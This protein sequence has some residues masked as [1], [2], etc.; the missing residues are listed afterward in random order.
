MRPIKL[1]MSAFGPYAE[2]EVLELDKLGETGLYLITG[3]TGAGKTTIFDAIT[4]ALYGEASGDSREASMMRSKYADPQTPTYVELTFLYNG[5][6]YTIHRV[7]EYMRPRV[8]G[9]GETKQKSEAVLTMPDGQVIDKLTDVNAKIIEIV[10]INRNQFVQIAMI[11]Q[12]DFQKLLL[13]KTEDRQKIFREIF[14]TKM[15]QI[16]QN[17]LSED[18]SLLNRQCEDE[19]HAISQYLSDISAD[20]NSPY[21]SKVMEIEDGAYMV[22]EAMGLILKV[23][24]EDNGEIE[25]KRNLVDMLSKEVDEIKDKI[26][27]GS[28]YRKTIENIELAKGAIDK[29][30]IDKEQAD[31]KLKE[32][33]DNEPER[34][35]IIKEIALIKKDMG[36]YSELDDILKQIE[37]YKGE[38]ESGEE[39]LIEKKKSQLEIRDKLDEDKKSLKNL[40]S[41][42]LNHQKKKAKLDVEN[43]KQNTLN[44]LFEAMDECEVIS[45]EYDE[46]VDNYKKS[47]VSSNELHEEYQLKNRLFMD[48]QAGILAQGL[49]EGQPC[50][51]CGSTHHPL[52]AKTDQEAPTQQELKDAEERANAALNRT[53]EL[54]V[55]AGEKKATR[56]IKRDNVADMQEKILGKI[57]DGDISEKLEKYQEELTETIKT[58]NEDIKKLQNDINAKAKLEKGIPDLEIKL[59]D[60]ERSILETE[61]GIIEHKTKLESDEKHRD[62]IKKKLRYADKSEAESAVGVLEDKEKEMK[63]QLKAWDKNANELG[64]RL[65]EIKGNLVELTKRKDALKEYDVDELDR[66]L[67]EKN[68][69]IAEVGD[70][71]NNIF[72][73]VEANKKAYDNVSKA[74][75][76]LLKLEEKWKWQSSIS[77]TANGNVAGKERIMLETYIQSTY[78]DRVLARAAVRL[79]R[80]SGGQYELV[81]KKTAKDLRSQTGL[82][83]DVI[84]HNASDS[85]LRDVSTLSGGEQ[86]MASLSLALGLSDEIRDSAGGIKL[87]AMFVDEGFGSLSENV[88][89]EA[90]KVLTELSTDGNRLIG[91]ISHVAD[92]KNKSVNKIVVEKSRKK[93]S[94][95]RIELE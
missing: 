17:R 28:D 56:D 91:I 60:I 83:I 77:K 30:K 54:S 27:T 73:R 8:K 81:R 90:W 43:E 67:T 52:L 33:R 31:K 3:D 68:E 44:Q 84:D 32:L 63:E 50:R 70:D 61:K 2:K 11:A 71:I 21:H 46:A 6:E 65:A 29:V 95:A 26:K 22:D 62:D 75:E 69:R 38:I 23:I 5:K 80:M 48:N 53:N 86:F 25:K 36:A 76:R 49:E 59:Q 20:E 74:S 41:A 15:F 19:R 87:D 40:G 82:A 88:L 93:G 37:K 1:T 64:Q 92:L 39:L 45:K 14:G 10:R 24:D 42:E 12:G 72:A 55:I 78:F 57:S 85:A 51:V 34:E 47:S 18:T 58:L 16:L 9:D 89:E 66:L 7:P 13:A 4:Y 79:S 35:K 94:Q